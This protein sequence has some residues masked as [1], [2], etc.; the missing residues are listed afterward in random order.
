MVSDKRRAESGHFRQ[1]AMGCASGNSTARTM[2]FAKRM[3]MG[4]IAHRPIAAQNCSPGVDISDR[5]A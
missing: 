1:E 4:M 3:M 5:K 2:R